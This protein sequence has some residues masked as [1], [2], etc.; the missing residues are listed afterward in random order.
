M[1]MISRSL[2]AT[3]ADAVRQFQGFGEKLVDQQ[4]KAFTEVFESIH[5]QFEACKT[6][7]GYPVGMTGES[8]RELDRRAKDRE[9]T[10][11]RRN[12]RQAKGESRFV[13]G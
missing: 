8:T 9:L 10:M 13:E 2:V 6:P 1:G 12:A 11:Q 5:D 7:R 3:Y 4:G